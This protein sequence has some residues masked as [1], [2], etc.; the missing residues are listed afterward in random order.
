MIEAPQ[1]ICLDI[2]FD[3]MLDVEELTRIARSTSDSIMTVANNTLQTQLEGV[4][5]LQNPTCFFSL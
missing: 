2:S 1:D 3:A 4:I 5:R